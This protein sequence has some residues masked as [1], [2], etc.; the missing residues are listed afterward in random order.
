VVGGVAFAIGQFACSNFLSVEITDI[1]ASLLSAGAIVALLR[2]WQP[3]EP[4]QGEARFVRPAI[5]GASTADAVHEQEV[6]R[7]SDDIHDSRGDVIKAYAPYIIIVAVLSL[8]QWGPIKTALESV[9]QEI[10]WPGLNV[11]NADG[12]EPGPAVFKLNWAITPG[13]LLLVSGC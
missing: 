8:A 7:R 13:T 11:V 6:R 4:M 2:V 9:T 12:E 5:A 10:D 1:V 3:A